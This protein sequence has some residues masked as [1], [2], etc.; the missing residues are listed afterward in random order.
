MKKTPI[1]QVTDL[2]LSLEKINL[3][4]LSACA[5]V[6]GKVKI[7][8]LPAKELKFE[9]CFTIPKAIEEDRMIAGVMYTATD[10]EVYQQE[11]ENEV[12]EDKIQKEVVDVLKFISNKQL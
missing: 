12:A 2:C 9:K 10:A 6:S 8:P 5:K 4:E 7:G 11:N 1:P 3:K